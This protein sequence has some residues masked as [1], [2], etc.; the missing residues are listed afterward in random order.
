MKQNPANKRLNLKSSTQN[1]LV[2]KE[3]FLKPQEHLGYIDAVIGVLKKLGYN[4]SSRLLPLIWL[5]FSSG[6]PKLIILAR[7]F[8]ASQQ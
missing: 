1:D 2:L 8:L 6:R 5:G 3:L 4:I 7:V